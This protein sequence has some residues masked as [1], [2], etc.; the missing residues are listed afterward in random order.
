MDFAEINNIWKK[1][2]VEIMGEDALNETL[3]T[4]TCIK[5]LEVTDNLLKPVGQNDIKTNIYYNLVSDCIT[6]PIYNLLLKNENEWF[7]KDQ[8]IPFE[9]R[10][11]FLDKCIIKDKK[12]DTNFLIHH[13]QNMKA[14]G[15][16]TFYEAINRID[17]SHQN[18][19]IVFLRQVGALLALHIFMVDYNKIALFTKMMGETN[20]LPP[21][22]QIDQLVQFT[23]E[24]D[25]ELCNEIENIKLGKNNVNYWNNF[26]ITFAGTL[27]G[28][29]RKIIE[30]YDGEKSINFFKK[31][32][33]ID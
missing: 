28:E 25:D 6:E 9:R 26:S 11:F 23:L 5:R 24:K 3:Y 22:A 29:N 19:K 20:S 27:S 13:Y 21:H 31:V 16:R 7:N 15:V 4:N 14:I 30:N 10:Q 33:L 1:Y 12:F 32:F 17:S 8:S 2:L 18:E